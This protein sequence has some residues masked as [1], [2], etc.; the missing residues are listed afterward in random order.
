M[1]NIKTKGPISP[2]SLISFFSWIWIIIIVKEGRKEAMMKEQVYMGM[3]MIKGK[4][5]ENKQRKEKAT[6]GGQPRAP[7]VLFRSVVVIDFMV[8]LGALLTDAWNFVQ[9][10]LVP[11]E[12]DPILSISLSV[13]LPFFS[14]VSTIP[15]SHFFWCY[16]RFLIDGQHS[17]IQ[18]VSNYKNT[19]L[20]KII[21][22]RQK[23]KK[24]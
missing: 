18:P 12:G 3:D 23:Q 14:F 4:R 20:S 24:S 7:S 5:K 6:V 1:G 19:I 11:R 15:T 13:S 8:C 16:Q 10:S 9:Y 22:I 2:Q 17:H 21:N